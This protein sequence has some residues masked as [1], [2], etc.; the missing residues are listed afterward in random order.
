VVLSAQAQGVVKVYRGRVERYRGYQHV[1]GSNWT[2]ADVTRELD[3]YRQRAEADLYRLG[4]DRRQVTELLNAADRRRLPTPAHNAT[5]YI[6]TLIRNQRADQQPSK[7][8]S[9]NDW[10]RRQSGR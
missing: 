8:E 10:I 6:N 7:A 4:Y 3:P 9:M 5:S 1:H 2:D